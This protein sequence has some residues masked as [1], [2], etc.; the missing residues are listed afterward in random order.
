MDVKPRSNKIKR[1]EGRAEE[2]VRQGGKVV[3]ATMALLAERFPLVGGKAPFRGPN[4]LLRLIVAGQDVHQLPASD[5]D[6]VARFFARIDPSRSR[7]DAPLTPDMEALGRLV[8]ICHRRTSFFRGTDA[9]VY[10][11]VLLALSAHRPCWVREPDDWKPRTFDARWQLHALARHLLARY[12]VPIFMNS[13][14]LEGLTEQSL[15]HQRWFIHVAQGQNIR[16]A[17]GLPIPLT[18]KQ[19]HHYLQAPGDFDVLGEFRWAQ[20]V[21]P[22]WSN[23]LVRGVLWTRLRT[24]FAHDE[25]WVSVFRWLISHPM[26][27]PVHYGPII[28]FLHN[29]RF[30]PRVLNPT[31]RRR[32][33]PRMA[34]AQPNLTIKDWSPENL[35]ASVAAWHQRLA[36]P[37]QTLVGERPQPMASWKPSGIG[38]F[39]FEQVVADVRRVYTI[40]E[41]LS[42]C[43]LD[44]E[45]R[46]MGHC[47]GSYASSCVSGRISI[48]SLKKVAPTE[49]ATRLLTLEVS[50]QDRQIVQARRVANGL[51]V[52]EEMQ[53]LKRWTN[54]GGPALSK[55]LA[56]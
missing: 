38:P 16:T 55:W 12:D 45:G 52:P 20:I 42:T 53:I 13:V 32:G 27:A 49:E 8:L 33:R 19:A 41:L 1:L 47:V 28:D 46:M 37:M 22:G 10:A 35:L 51:P 2:R 15:V 7:G 14:W 34:P 54:E 26:L 29:Q 21:Q 36:T 43:E 17:D 11:N 56:R 40:T 6:G 39:R 30:V 5:L 25:F 9:H 24:D 31:A 3:A 23:R 48:W 44:E 18:R 50:N 4:Q